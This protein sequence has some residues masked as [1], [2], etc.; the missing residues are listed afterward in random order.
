MKRAHTASLL[1]PV[2]LAGC[3]AA[4]A[5]AIHLGL[6]WDPLPRAPVLP[7][8]EARKNASLAEPS[9]TMPPLASFSETVARPLFSETRRPMAEPAMPKA[10]AVAA[11]SV[12]AALV[13]IVMMPGERWALVRGL[14]DREP[15]RILEG[16]AIDGW[17]V[18]KILAD[19]IVVESDRLQEIRLR[20][21]P[22]SSTAPSVPESRDR[23]R[24]GAAPRPSRT[25]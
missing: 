2:I 15:Q 3:C 8:P 21:E 11:R 23:R 1:R 4:F 12:E 5:L 7:P 17:R 10:A 20:P 25:P 13:G 22:D 14:S 19:R 16:Q 24:N 6:R 9:F 18:V